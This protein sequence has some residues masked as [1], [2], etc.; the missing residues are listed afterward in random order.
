MANIVLNTSNVTEIRYVRNGITTNITEIN[1]KKGSSGSTTPVWSLGLDPTIQEV[2]CTHNVIDNGSYYT[3]S[4]TFT[5][6]TT[7]LT[8]SISVLIEAAGTPLFGSNSA[9]N[10][11]YFFYLLILIY[12]YYYYILYIITIVFIWLR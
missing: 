7:S 4:M 3:I 5:R 6:K 8:S 12:T 2:T 11:S 9:N 1:Y 10:F